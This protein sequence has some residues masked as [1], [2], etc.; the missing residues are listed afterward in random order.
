ML[1]L[2][3][4][5]ETFVLHTKAKFGEDGLEL[6]GVDMDQ[7]DLFLLASSFAL[8]SITFGGFCNL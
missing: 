8:C 7:L 2:Y 1:A 5:S 3:K 4:K 6:V